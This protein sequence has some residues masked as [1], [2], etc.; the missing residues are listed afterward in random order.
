MAEGQILPVYEYHRAKLDDAFVKENPRNIGSIKLVKVM[1]HVSTAVVLNAIT[2]IETGDSTALNIK[3]AAKSN[4][5]GGSEEELGEA[6]S[7]DQTAT[8]KKPDEDIKLDEEKPAETST[9]IKLDE[10][11]PPEPG[12]EGEKSSELK[13]DETPP[14]PPEIKTE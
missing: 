6:K 1:E 11:K 13:L 9:D 8:E 12:L 10:E 5:E 7:A 14:P 3:S 2:E 4:S